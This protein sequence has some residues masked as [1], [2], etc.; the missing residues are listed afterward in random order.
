MEFIVETKNLTKKFSNKVAVNKI[1]MHI[2]KGDIYGFIGKN[3]AGKT[4]AMKMILGLLNPSDGE[5]LINGSKELD[6]E[7]RKIGS[8]I[9]NPGL[10]KNCTAYENLKRFSII[11]GG[12]DSDIK[13]ILELVGLAD[14][15]KKKA[16]KFSLG[17]KQR[18]GI[19][20][21]LLGNPELLVLDEPI[22]GLDPAGIKEIRDLLVKL[23]K[24]RDVTI[25]ISSHILDEL[26]KITTT[27][28]IINEGSL[29]E[30]V[31]SEELEENCKRNLMIKVND[32]DNATKILESNNLL[33]E[34]EVKGDFIY[35][36][37]NF[38]KAALINSL[39]V[40][41]SIE[42]SELTNNEIGLEEY[43]IERLG[44]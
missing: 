16:G 39:L 33:G 28:G 30:E 12:N 26:A 36:Y 9:E 23:N 42:V 5:I 35:L 3:G 13:E 6:K 2:K 27:Y 1:N 20:I 31:S 43:F 44:K 17:M 4:T 22:N 25:L 24:E 32:I 18:L 19:G 11:Y 15:G 10:Y 38:D 29:I 7:R 14:T 8:L 37:S 41:N 21:A 40:K 34:Y